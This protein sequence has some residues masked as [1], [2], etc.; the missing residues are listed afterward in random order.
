MKNCHAANCRSSKTVTART[1]WSSGTPK[2][3]WL[4]INAWVT[5]NPPA[6]PLSTW[7]V[8]S[9]DT[10]SECK[11]NSSNWWCNASNP[12]TKD[13]P[14]LDKNKKWPSSQLNM[15]NSITPTDSFLLADSIITLNPTTTREWCSEGSVP[16]IS[17]VHITNSV[18]NSDFWIIRNET[19][20]THPWR[21]QW[22][23]PPRNPRKPQCL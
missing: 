1:R 23:L 7:W 16:D 2:S 13:S 17:S 11:C 14:C 9:N 3:N 15:T 4:T 8:S 20:K 5:L 12:I 19:L 18:V 21:N 10:N 6:P 22:L